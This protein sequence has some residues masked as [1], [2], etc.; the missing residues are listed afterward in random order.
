MKHYKPFLT[1]VLLLLPAFAFCQDSV[2]NTV[3]S[4]YFK[5]TDSTQATK[6]ELYTRARQFIALQFKDSKAVIQMDDK[7]AGKLIGK[8]VFVLYAVAA[9]GI[10]SG[11]YI[12]FTVTIDVKDNKYRCVLSDFYHTGIVGRTDG[13]GVG[14]DLNNEKPEGGIGRKYWVRIKD[15]TYQEAQKFIKD[16]DNA[17]KSPAQSDNF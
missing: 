16:F 9:L 1:I 8:G 15:A 3:D 14:G 6:S 17:M 5:L 13:G 11:S 7:E 10:S 2:K 4:F 12:E